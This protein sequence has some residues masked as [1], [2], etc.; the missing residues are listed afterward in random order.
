MELLITDGVHYWT[1]NIPDSEIERPYNTQTIELSNSNKKIIL[2]YFDKS[3][4]YPKIIRTFT[5]D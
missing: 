5:L 4:E 3:E 1:E 2:V